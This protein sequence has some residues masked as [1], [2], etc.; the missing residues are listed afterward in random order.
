MDHLIDIEMN[1]DQDLV[2]DGIARS[3][4]DLSKL[5]EVF[6]DPMDA[7][8]CSPVPLTIRQI[9][10]LYEPSISAADPSAGDKITITLRLRVRSE[11]ERWFERRSI[12]QAK[13]SSVHRDAILRAEGEILVMQSLD[14]G[15]RVLQSKIKRWEVLDAFITEALLMAERGEG[16]FPAPLRDAMRALNDLEKSIADQ[17]PA[18]D[19]AAYAERK[20]TEEIAAS[21]QAAVAPVA[22]LTDKERVIARVGDQ[23]RSM[24]GSDMAGSVFDMIR[25]GIDKP[26]LRLVASSNVVD[27][28]EI[29]GGGDEEP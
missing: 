5:V 2:I 28:S 11:N 12:F 13:R 25:V 17:L 1:E 6:P 20:K 26:N 23:L 9:A 21:A 27:S 15:R 19:L 29:D 16:G 22:A 7:Y 24:E 4:T 8:I 14:F 3:K 10:D 18:L